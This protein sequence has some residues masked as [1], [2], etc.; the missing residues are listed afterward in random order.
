M[1]ILRD[2]ILQEFLTP[3][4]FCLLSLLVVFFLGRGFVQMADLVFNKNVN[5]FLILKLL[6]FSF[7]FIL[8]FLIPM[9]VLVATLLAFG[10]LSFDNEIMAIRA[11]GISMKQ[12]I[13]PLI[14]LTAVLCL[15]SFLLSD[16]IASSRPFGFCRGL[17]RGG[18]G[19]APGGPGGGGVF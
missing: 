3:F 12:I 15:L 9:S 11:S 2:H 10:K 19:R 17:G 13:R 7:P 6:F 5:I 4:I 18:G 14:A 16:R 1:K 8:T